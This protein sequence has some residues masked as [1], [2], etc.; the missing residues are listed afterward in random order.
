MA[1]SKSLANMIKVAYRRQYERVPD[2]PGALKLAGYEVRGKVIG[3]GWWRPYYK[4]E[5]IE[6]E[7]WGK[8][9]KELQTKECSDLPVDFPKLQ[10][11]KIEKD[12]TKVLEVI[13]K[14]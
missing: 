14:E 8:V 1:K 10:Q 5:A 13:L 9:T 12:K 11:N 2:A 4:V 7:Y 6:A 3:D